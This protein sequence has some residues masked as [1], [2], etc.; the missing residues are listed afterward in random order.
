MGDEVGVYHED[1]LKD[2]DK[3]K[4]KLLKDECIRIVKSNSKINAELKKE[5][6]PTYRRLKGSKT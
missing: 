1:D 5:L 3:E 4:R 2:L 6:D